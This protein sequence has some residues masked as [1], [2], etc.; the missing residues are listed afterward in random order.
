MHSK[1]GKNN[2]G[3]IFREAGVLS[4]VDSLDIPREAFSGRWE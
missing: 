2:N 1:V 3:K 4:S